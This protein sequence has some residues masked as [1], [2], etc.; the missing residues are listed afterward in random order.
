MLKRLALR[1]RRRWPV[2]AALLVLPAT[3]GVALVLRGPAVSHEAPLVR[4][5]A[6]TMTA[7]SRA[8]PGPLDGRDPITGRDVRLAA[9][10]GKPLVLVVWASWCSVCNADAATIRAAAD[11]HPDVQFVGIDILDERPAAAAFYRRHR[12]TFPS[13]EDPRQERMRK[14]GFPGQPSFAFVDAGGRIVE[15]VIG[16]ATPETLAKGIAAARA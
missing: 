1:S 10:R 2:I 7:D 14:L 4:A 8:R 6:E 3:A 9:F 15:R 12:W 13:I 5:G 11:A 16:P